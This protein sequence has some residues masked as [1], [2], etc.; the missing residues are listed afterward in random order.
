M[1][2]PDDLPS[3]LLTH[4]TLQLYSALT[5]F[6]LTVP[7]AFVGKWSDFILHVNLELFLFL[8]LRLTLKCHV[9]S[10]VSVGFCMPFLIISN[11]CDGPEDLESHVGLLFFQS[12][13]QRRMATFE[14]G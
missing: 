1:D 3:V 6:E 8:I 2:G 13:I 5:S 11:A 7:W 10:I 12:Y 14:L 4:I 9:V